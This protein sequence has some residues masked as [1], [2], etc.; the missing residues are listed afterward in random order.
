MCFVF[1]RPGAEDRLEAPSPPKVSFF[2]WKGGVSASGLS[3][4]PVERHC[5]AL[6][7]I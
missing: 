6:L 7:R 1:P 5:I 3:Y 2:Q 4:A